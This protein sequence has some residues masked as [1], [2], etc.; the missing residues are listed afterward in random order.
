[1]PPERIL[2]V[3]DGMEVGGSQRQITHLLA[4]LDRSRW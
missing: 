4:G 2:V 3:I 1:M